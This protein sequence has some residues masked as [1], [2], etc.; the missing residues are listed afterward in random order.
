MRALSRLLRVGWLVTGWSWRL[1]RRLPLKAQAVVGVSLAVSFLLGAVFGEPPATELETSPAA[2]DESLPRA[3]TT[4]TRRVSESTYTVPTTVTTAY[5]PPSTLPPT[6][7][8]P[9]PAPTYAAAPSPGGAGCHKSYSPCIADEGTDVD[10][11]GGTG[12]GP[13]YVRGPVQVSGPDEY[14]LDRDGNGVG[15]ESSR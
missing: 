6:T 4:V 11:A 3:A 9:T 1:F 13:R 8:A 12:N 14:D 10:C 7:T 5:V 15:C 2:L